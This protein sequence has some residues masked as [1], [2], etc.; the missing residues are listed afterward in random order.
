MFEEF[1]DL[2]RFRGGELAWCNGSNW[3][4][5]IVTHRSHCYAENSCPLRFGGHN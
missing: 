1:D 5:G 4:A 2:E 3:G